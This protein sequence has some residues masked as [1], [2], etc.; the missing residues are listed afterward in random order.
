MVSEEMAHGADLEVIDNTVGES[1]ENSRFEKEDCEPG[2]SV[3]FV[4][5]FYSVNV[6]SGGSSNCK[7]ESG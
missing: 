5:T 4:G 7:Y 2:M 3:L 1:L 6:G